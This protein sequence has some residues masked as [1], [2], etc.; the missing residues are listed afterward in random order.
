M[1]C[2]AYDHRMARGLETGSDNRIVIDVVTDLPGWMKYLPRRRTAQ[3]PW[4]WRR[5]REP[6]GFKPFIRLQPFPPARRHSVCDY[7]FSDPADRR[8][9]T[10]IPRGLLPRSP[11]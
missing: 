4:R 6:V 1:R 11:P 2:K 8:S 9:A 10:G 5:V 3:E 7:A